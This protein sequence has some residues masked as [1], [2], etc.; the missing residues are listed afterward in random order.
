[1]KRRSQVCGLVLLVTLASACEQKPKAE[2]APT[3]SA[4]APA[5][6]STAA[7]QMFSVDRGSSKVEFTMDAE[8]EKITGRAPNALEGELYV[9]FKDITKSSGLVKLDLDQLSIYQRKRGKGQAEFG[10]ETRNDKQNADLRTWFEIASDAPPEVRE[11]NRWTEFKISKITNPSV[12]DLSAQPGTERRATATIVGDF[13]LHGRVKERS[14]KVEI[15]ATYQGD[16]PLKLHIKTLEPLAV[17]LEEHDVRP[18]T[19]F[20]QLA[21]KTLDALG[22]KVAKVAMV[23]LDFTAAPKAEAPQ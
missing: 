16:Q 1:M 21:D 19:A 23:S 7:A 3:S 10:E 6:P 8:L 22:T 20:S 18:R 12:S 14:A 11:K 9:D 17:G 2:L 4:L 15:T 5:K 13:R